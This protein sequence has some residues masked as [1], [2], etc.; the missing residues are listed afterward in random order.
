[1]R[2]PLVTNWNAE[3]KVCWISKM[4]LWAQYECL[5]EDRNEGSLYASCIKNSSTEEAG[6]DLDLE[7]RICFGVGGGSTGE[8]D[9]LANAQRK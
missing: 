5:W 3:C 1:M 7:G 8:G 4:L 9:G 6:P 2:I